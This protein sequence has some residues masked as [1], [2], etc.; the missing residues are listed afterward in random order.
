M[1]GHQGAGVVDG[2]GLRFLLQILLQYVCDTS[3]HPGTQD[4]EVSL[5]FYCQ[6]SRFSWENVS[7]DFSHRIC[8]AICSTT[9]CRMHTTVSKI[10]FS[11]SSCLPTSSCRLSEGQCFILYATEHKE[12]HCR[13]TCKL[14]HSIVFAVF[15]FFQA[16]GQIK[17]TSPPDTGWWLSGALCRPPALSSLGSAGWWAPE[18]PSG[19]PPASVPTPP[20]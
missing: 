2:L 14:L 15:L 9:C 19:C 17:G 1:R 3:V 18:F 6:P 5:W 7:E 10:S 13:C 11:S 12:H 20:S 8:S 16:M 4:K